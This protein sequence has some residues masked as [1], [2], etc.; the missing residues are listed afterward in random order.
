VHLYTKDEGQNLPATLIGSSS[1]AGIAEVRIDHFWNVVSGSY[2]YINNS[3]DAKS[4]PLEPNEIVKRAKENLGPHDYNVLTN[5][6]EHFVNECRYGDGH[7]TSKQVDNAKTALISG[8][9]I[10][11]VCLAAVFA[12]S[13]TNKKNKETKKHLL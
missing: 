5:N 7:R 9:S 2:V 1:T 8:F 10:G 12:Y 6:C 13:T 11:A 3:K 4:K